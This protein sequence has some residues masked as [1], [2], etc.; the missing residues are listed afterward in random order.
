MAALPST[1][2]F[3]KIRS[4][5]QHDDSSLPLSTP[6]LDPDSPPPCSLHR[7]NL[8]SCVYRPCGHDACEGC[9][10][11]SIIN[12]SKCPTCDEPVG[13]FVGFKKPIAK[14]SPGRG[15]SGNWWTIEKQIEGLSVDKRDTENVVTL[16]LDE[17]RVSSLHGKVC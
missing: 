1:G 4:V 13:A 15:S 8:A 3:D 10:G 14:V 11:K 9:L 12:G 2:R 16:F 7:G 5:R 6:M 17:D